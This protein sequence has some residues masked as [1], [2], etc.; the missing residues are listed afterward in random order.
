MNHYS[1]SDL[2]HRLSCAL[3][4]NGTGSPPLPASSSLQYT[5]VL[6]FKGVS[7]TA[8]CNVLHGAVVFVH[9]NAYIWS[10]ISDYEVAV[11]ALG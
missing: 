4:Y 3:A 7:A 2:P 11:V 8:P 10:S 9:E 6:P 1:G 5:R